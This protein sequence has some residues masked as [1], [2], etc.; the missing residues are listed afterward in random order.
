MQQ[1]FIRLFTFTSLPVNTID[2]LH[3]VF[4]DGIRLCEG[5]DY[6]ITGQTVSLTQTHEDLIGLTVSLIIFGTMLEHTNYS[7]LITDPGDG[8]DPIVAFEFSQIPTDSIP[9]THM[10]FLGGVRLRETTAALAGD[11]TI[12]GKTITLSRTDKDLIGLEITLTIFS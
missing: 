7:D 6:T 3:M 5:A 2:D 11:Y 4:L 12:S 9:S 1:S 10:L 8:T